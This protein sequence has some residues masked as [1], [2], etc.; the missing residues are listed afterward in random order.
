MR[1]AATV[2][3]AVAAALSPTPALAEDAAEPGTI[4]LQGRCDYRPEIAPYV[5]ERNG[6][7]VC[8]TVVLTQGGEGAAVEFLR[9]SFG[10]SVR[11][12]GAWSGDT[13]T[14]ARVQP[15][16]RPLEP[17]QGYCRVFYR[18]GAISTV[19]CVANTRQLAFAAN[20][21]TRR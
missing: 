21:V 13:M 18:D 15:R 5:D 11:Y 9:E 1:T 14:I 20:F 6:F 10:S 17:A 16:D 2:H 4:R 3:L 8:D 7:A 19:T 12:E